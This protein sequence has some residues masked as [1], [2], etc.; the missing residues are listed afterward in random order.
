MS[1]QDA[2]LSALRQYATFTGRA[3]RSEFWWFFLFQWVA[4]VVA[5]LL[6]AALSYG[7]GAPSPLTLLVVLGLV[8]PQLAVSWR[9][10]H[11]TGRSGAWWFISLV[12]FGSIVLLVLECADSQPFTNQ[13]GPSPEQ[14]AGPGYGPGHGQQQYGQPGYGQP[15]HGQPGH[16]PQGY[17]G[18]PPQQG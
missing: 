6:D 3:R 16:G 18:Q 2:V 5:L 13:F 8:V 14:L 17:Y 1:P 10:L 4:V 7:L 11:D 9:R 12:P 15:G